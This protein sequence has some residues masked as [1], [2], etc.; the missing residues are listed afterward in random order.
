MEF[1]SSFAEILLITAV[2]AAFIASGY[3]LR[4]N[5]LF[6]DGVMP[7]LYNLLL[8]VGQPL[9]MIRAFA[10]DPVEPSSRIG[11]NMLWVALLSLINIFIA[12]VISKL[13]F[14]GGGGR[15]KESIFL[16]LRLFGLRIYRHSLCRHNDGRGR[17]SA[18]LHGGI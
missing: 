1:A 8:Y 9:L 17:R 7:A 3:I 16:C 12:S 4:K 11:I 5:N 10:A 18:S 13:A 6:G 14:P 2:F 15:K